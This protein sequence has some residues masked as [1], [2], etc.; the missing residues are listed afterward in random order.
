MKRSQPGCTKLHP[1]FEIPPPPEYYY[2]IHVF[3][4]LITPQLPALP[5]WSNNAAAP[6]SSP[7]LCIFHNP[8]C[9][10]GHQS[11]AESEA[12][13]PCSCRAHAP[14]HSKLR[15]ITPVATEVHVTLRSFVV[16]VWM[17]DT[18]ELV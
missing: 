1:P 9:L 16:L 4:V 10:E 13:G 5:L 11:S 3:G 12:E 2:F 8:S 15:S 6:T 17:R 18:L 14:V 7:R